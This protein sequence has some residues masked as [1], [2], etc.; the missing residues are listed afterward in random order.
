[1]CATHTTHTTHP[2]TAHP[3]TPTHTHTHTP[4]PPGGFDQK[5]DF[6]LKKIV[7]HPKVNFLGLTCC[8]GVL[9]PKKKFFFSRVQ[10]LD[11]Q[12]TCGIRP[13]ISFFGHFYLVKHDTCGMLPSTGKCI[14]KPEKTHVICDGQKCKIP[15]LMNFLSTSYTWG[16]WSDHS[17]DHLSCTTKTPLF[18]RAHFT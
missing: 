18:N 2:H 14:E 3:H 12:M 4:S 5:I 11:C 9:R 10:K 13:K 6:F 7:A 1:M 15:S 17:F 8:L 16:I